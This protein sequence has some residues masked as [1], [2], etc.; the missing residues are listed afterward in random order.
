MRARAVGLGLLLFT[1]IAPNLQGQEAEV[2]SAVRATLEAWT[3]GDYESFVASYH[4]AARGFFLDGSPLMRGFN[5]EALRA[6][7]DAGF[8][9]DVELSDLDVKIYGGMSVSV[10]YLAGTLTM[11]GGLRLPGTWRY[12]ETRVLDGGTW[13]IVQFH[14]SPRGEADPG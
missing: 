9:A 14:I 6:A 8:R 5:V 10:G 12:S 4:E 2:A 1:W 3:S 11:P 7:A 13:K